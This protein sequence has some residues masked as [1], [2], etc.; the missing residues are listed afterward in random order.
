MLAHFN[1]SN[2]K[3]ESKELFNIKNKV[4]IKEK[5]F[6]SLDKFNDLDYPHIPLTEDN[7][8]KDM[9]RNIRNSMLK[10]DKR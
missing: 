4:D 8:P 7:I 9:P 3:S 6:R 5:S 10:F 2:V 1:V